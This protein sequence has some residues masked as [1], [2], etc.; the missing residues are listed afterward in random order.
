M[1]NYKRILSYKIAVEGLN[2]P[3]A[4]SFLPI[5]A[6][7]CWQVGRGSSVNGD[8][9]MLLFLRQGRDGYNGNLL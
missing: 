8:F 5:A 2:F 3:T 1:I 9:L 4:K 6:F 7:L